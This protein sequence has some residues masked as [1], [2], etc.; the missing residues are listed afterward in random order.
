M[1]CY[2]CNSPR[3]VINNRKDSYI[4]KDC[5][6]EHKKQ[7]FFISHSHKDIEKVRIIRNVIEETFFYEPILFFLKC[8]SEKTEIED[9]IKR[10]INER[11]WFVYCK[12]K[13][14]EKS[15]YVRME[16]E[17]IEERIKEGYHIRVLVIDL[18]K[19]NVW[20]KECHNY[21]REQIAYKVK[22]ANVFVS[23][24]HYDTDI[25]KKVIRKLRKNTFTVF[26]DEEISIGEEWNRQIESSIK[27]HSYK[28]GVVLVLCSY[29]SLNSK[30][31]IWELN[32]AI[33]YKA[34]IIPVIVYEG[35]SDLER[36]RNF[37]KTEYPE[38]IHN[39]VL[40]LNRFKDRK[41]MDQLVDYL[42]NY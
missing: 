32:E 4:C 13:N 37:L 10:E 23:Y 11:I 14:A 27:Y 25:A 28:E 41:G 38:L 31:L 34:I 12:S 5:R 18:D 30:A 9:L 6:Y 36:I 15:E 20:D 21:I 17:Y 26:Y 29:R 40:E 35:Y 39:E 3:L 19:Y 24:S 8:L 16:R 22:K 33:H 2:N 42:M 1:R 7:Y